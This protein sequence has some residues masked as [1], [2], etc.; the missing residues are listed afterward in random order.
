MTANCRRCSGLESTL[1]PTSSTT[2]RPRR[3]GKYRGERRPVDAGKRADQQLRRDHGRAGVAGADHRLGPPFAHQVGADD[4]RG[5][6][7]RRTTVGGSSISMRLL[8]VHDLD[9]AA[10]LSDR[11]QP[12][13]SRPSRCSVPHQQDRS[14]VLHG[15]VRTLRA[16]R[17]AER[18]RRPS[19][20]RRCASKSVD[21][22]SSVEPLSAGLNVDRRRVRD[23]CRRTGRRD[24]GACARRTSGRPTKPAESVHHGHGACRGGP[25]SDVVSDSASSL[26]LFRFRCGNQLPLAAPPLRGSLSIASAAHRGSTRS[27]TQPQRPSFKSCP[28]CGHKP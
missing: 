11:T 14:S 22:R 26:P 4:E 19:R 27:R 1:A 23:R 3:I 17:R 5:P 6:A 8:G 15:G 18:S 10:A 9:P 16:P 12:R 7:L 28:H 25:W 24:A 21:S 20:R 2:V 13:S